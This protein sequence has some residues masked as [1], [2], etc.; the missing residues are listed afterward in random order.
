[1]NRLPIL[2]VLAILALPAFGQDAPRM[3]SDV[4]ATSTDRRGEAVSVREDLR[5]RSVVANVPFRNVGPTIMSGR[6]ADL[7]V[8]TEDATHFYV[9]YASGG[10][11]KTE[12]NGISF[13]PLFDREPVMT[14]GD[15]AVDWERN[16]I[17]VGTGEK[18]SSRSSYAG[19]GIYRSTDGGMT[20][21]HRGLE[22]TQ[23]TGRIVLSRS[24]PDVVWVAAVGRLYGPNNERGVYKTTDGGLSW[25]RVLFVD[26]N[27]GAIDLIA[28]PGNPDILYAA[29]WHRERRAW[30]FVESGSGSGIFK[31]TDGGE[32]WNRITAEGSGFPTGDGVGRIG[33]DI[34]PGNTDTIVA[35]LDNQFR[36]PPDEEEEEEGLTRDALREMSIADF[37]ALA[38][39]VVEAYLRDNNF[40]EKYDAATVREMVEDGQIKPVALV[41]YLEDAD[42]QLYDTDI[43]GAEVY[44]SDDAGVTWRKTHDE[45]ID[46]LYA[47]YGYYFGEIRVA[48]DTPDRLYIQGVPMLRSLD[49]GAT[50]A[51]IDASN[52]HGDHQA[53]WIN[54]NRMGHLVS[55]NDGGVNISWDDGE[56]WFKANTPSVGQFYAIQVDDARP[57]NVYGGLQDNGVWVGPS[58]YEASYNWY[59]GG[60]YPYQR[61]YGGDGMQVEVDTRTNDVVYTGSQFGFYSRIDRSVSESTG[62]RPKHHLGERP[63]RFNWQSPILL[64]RHNQDILYFGANRL[65]RSMDRGETMEPISDDLTKG[66]RPGDVPY[67]TLT[68][69]DES[70]L[71][72]GLLY[73]GSDD[74]LVHV[75]RDGGVNWK[76]ISDKMPVDLW[77]SRVE[78]SNHAEGRVFVTL[79]GYRWDNFE[80]YV[81]R[82]DDYGET[83]TRIDD[84]LPSEP[85]NVIT[86][87]PEYED[88]LYL[89]T[90][91]AVYLSMN[92]GETWMAM[93]G[94]L[95]SV[96]VHDIRVQA[97]ERDLVVGTHGRGIWIAD[98][99]LV[100]HL[101]SEVMQSAV[102]VFETE[103]V[104]WSERWGAKR[105]S[106]SEPYQPS[107]DVAYWTGSAGTATIGVLDEDGT[108]LAEFP[109][110]S[111]RGLNYAE[112]DLTATADSLFE[113]ADDGNR[114]LTSGKY[115]IRVTAGDESSETALVVEER[116]R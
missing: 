96:A 25:R 62:I 36:Q 3:T 76:R 5:R 10:L 103:P 108:V 100:G 86:E 31:S 37:E 42:A 34:W 91:H 75:S 87:D 78:A 92:R 16:F 21:E 53:L 90:D 13:E 27:T 17:W 32:S 43:Y 30:N 94:G 93:D 26:E 51:S 6:V 12:N 61:L 11:W 111:D 38:D 58:T 9:A 64:S 105:A 77:V 18:N 114:Y 4:K 39:S 33:L 8:S 19:D 98:L 80:P 107:V 69:V 65:Y 68:A 54:P 24:D 60:R 2:L 81:Y 1:M 116:R 35:I 113:A 22:A 45:P 82:S 50:W 99:G 97:R 57:Y 102:H 41:E 20:W 52:M 79:N 40:P 59:G 104:T 23:H 14:I 83:W 73:V 56:T 115:T 101:T 67:G 74:G 72:F 66:G 55:G 70:P 48:P 29:M 15:I 44:R 112:Y 85:V 7:D 88:I 84:G 63:L 110:D 106:W 28:D 95:P 49:G 89:G 47:T 109:H 71:R 46:G